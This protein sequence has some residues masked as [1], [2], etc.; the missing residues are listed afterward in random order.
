MRAR[1]PSFPAVCLAAFVA[2]A[3][4]VAATSG[5]AEPISID[6]VTV[7]DPGNA[8]YLGS[9][10]TPYG[11]VGYQ[12]DIMKYEWTNA[13]Y[14]TF[15]NAIDPDGTN[16]NL[17][18]SGTMGSDARGGITNTGTVNGS[19]YAVKPNMGD[20]PTVFVTWFNAARVANWLHNGGQTYLTT[21]ASATAPQNVGA[22]TIGTGT[23]GTAPA[24]NPGAL[25][26]VPTE[27][28][29]VKAAFY[30][31]S[32]TNAGYWTYSTQSDSLPGTVTADVTGIGSAG[33]TGNFANYNQTADWNGFTNGNMTTIGT[34]GG[35]SAYDTYDMSGNV[36]EW[37]DLT[38][39]AG[40][41]RG[42]RGGNFAN[43]ATGLPVDGGRNATSSPALVSNIT[44]FRL[45]AVP[46]PSSTVMGV[47]CLAALAAWRLRKKR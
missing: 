7:G 5:R 9:G 47:G 23:D 12:Y 30:K 43:N 10:T 31:G 45:V 20:K 4:S 11:A 8:P 42:R 37:N 34:N 16:P 27:D 46:E 2:I 29:W 1:T 24:R 41:F 22:Y 26:G 25:Y 39:A 18:Y 19:R 32:G 14:T 33:P 28:E 36:V 17:V 6:W 40:T 21:D 35:P 3:G 13:Q 15:L 38:G 44:G